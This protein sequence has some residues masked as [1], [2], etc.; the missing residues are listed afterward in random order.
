MSRAELE[1]RRDAHAER[2]RSAE[3]QG[4]EH[5]RVRK[6]IM[7]KLGKINK[8]LGGLIEAGCDVINMQQPRT[9][10]IEDV[11]RELAG[12]I[13]FESLCDIQKTLPAGD[14]GEIEAEAELLLRYWGT[15]AGGFVLGDYGDHVAIGASP[16]TRQFMLDTFRRLDPYA[17]GW[18]W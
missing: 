15:P 8:A 2:L 11:G 17:S 3:L 14:R 1:A 10:G 5:K 9:N 6:R 12:K 16:E 18:R 4:D 13:C 7:A